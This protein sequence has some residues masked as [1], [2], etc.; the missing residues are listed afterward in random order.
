MRDTIFK[1]AHA[2]ASATANAL[3]TRPASCC[4][5]DSGQ[6][7]RGVDSPACRP[8]SD[9]PDAPLL[10]RNSLEKRRRG[11]EFTGQDGVRTSAETA[12]VKRAE[13][14]EAAL[15]G[16]LRRGVT[17]RGS[18][19]RSPHKIKVKT[20]ALIPLHHPYASIILYKTRSCFHWHLISLRQSTISSAQSSSR[21][22]SSGRSCRCGK[23]D[24]GPFCCR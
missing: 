12:S 1:R 6:K 7:L 5:P 14:M 22:P 15:P 17:A 20:A 24:G 21:R 4:P 16:T 3:R 8:A 13:G 10:L 9:T 19:S 23:L 18:E 11:T 2:K